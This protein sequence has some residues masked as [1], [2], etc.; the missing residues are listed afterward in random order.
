MEQA[1]LHSAVTSTANLV[2]KASGRKVLAI[3][4]RF[5]LIAF[6]R[7]IFLSFFG[8]PDEINTTEISLGRQINTD[9]TD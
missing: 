4:S 2:G 9:I 6:C 8:H 7:F 3:C 5:L 1:R